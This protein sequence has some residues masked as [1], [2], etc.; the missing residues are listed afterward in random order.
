MKYKNLTYLCQDEQQIRGILNMAK[1]IHPDVK[2]KADELL[3]HRR[4]ILCERVLACTK[5]KGVEWL[6]VETGLSKMTITRIHS[7]SSKL[8]LYTICLIDAVLIDNIPM[9]PNPNYQ[10]DR[11]R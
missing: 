9:A 8:N 7:L 2:K 3:E 1:N 11:E 10:S 6:S 5:A 4:R